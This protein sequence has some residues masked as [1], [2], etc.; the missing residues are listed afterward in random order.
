M[1][2][3]DDIRRHLATALGTAGLKAYKRAPGEVTAPAAVIAPDGIEYSTDFDGG[4]T[5][6]LP[7]VILIAQGDW[8]KAQETLDGYVSHDGTAVDAINETSDIEARVVSMSEYGI[9][10]WGTT[11]YFS[12]LLNVEVLV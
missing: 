9:V 4:A 5:Y 12:A 1:S 10:K 2:A 8:S 6:Q 3:L 11:D 7:V